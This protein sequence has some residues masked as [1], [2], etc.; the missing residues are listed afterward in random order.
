MQTSP[1]NVA[2]ESSHALSHVHTHTWALHEDSS[3]TRGV[4]QGH[5]VVNV[6]PWLTSSSHFV[7]LKR[8][9]CACVGFLLSH[10]ENSNSKHF[11]YTV[12]P[13]PLLSTW[14]EQDQCGKYCIILMQMSPQ[15][16]L[17]TSSDFLSSDPLKT[18]LSLSLTFFFS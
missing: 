9:R 16:P 5:I 11:I 3:Q 18:S 15:C 4:P 7:V 6:M 2:H 8:T 13:R 10:R 1:L 12:Q 14:G 17:M